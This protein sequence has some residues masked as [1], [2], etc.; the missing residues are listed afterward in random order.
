MAKDKPP[1]T[2]GKPKTCA[3][4]GKQA[5]FFSARFENSFCSDECFEAAQRGTN[6]QDAHIVITRKEG[7]YFQQGDI[8]FTVYKDNLERTL[9]AAQYGGEQSCIDKLMDSQIVSLAMANG[10]PCEP[11]VR[12]LVRSPLHGI[13]QITWYRDL[14]IDHDADHLAQNQLRRLGEYKRKLAAYQPGQ[15]NGDEPRHRTSKK[16][17]LLSHSFRVTSKTAAIPKGRAKQ[18]FDVLRSFK[19]GATL[20]QVI[21]A[22]NGKVKTKQPLEKIVTRFMNELIGDG[23]VEE[24]K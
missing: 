15:S 4:C 11:F 3:Y 20:A 9:A 1:V 18:V 12:E 19:D 17:S 24:V 2:D 21:E 13:I 23:A 10:I 8:K 7:T 6:P 5:K 16:A 14:K 22:A